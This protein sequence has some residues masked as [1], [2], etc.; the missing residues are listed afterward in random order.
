MTDRGSD[1][2]A[3][4]R[5][6]VLLEESADRLV[7]DLDQRSRLS[8]RERELARDVALL[9]AE[10]LPDVIRARPDNLRLA[11]VETRAKALEDWRLKTA[12]V[13]DRNGRLGRMDQAIAGNREQLEEALVAV[14]AELA[15]ARAELRA[16]IGTAEERK[17][18]RAA[19][20]LVNGAVRR[21]R[22][23]L[24]AVVTVVLGG[25]GYGVWRMRDDASRASGRLEQRL[26]QYD[27]DINRLYET[28]RAPRPDPTH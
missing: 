8:K 15:A 20:S 14:R 10:R 11:E 17:A 23:A 5:F 25:A 16:D 2:D 27:V 19:A 28:C 22:L 6:R 18:E 9:V 4:G 24:G 26:N 12:G 3:T 21:Y 13:D 7:E 1:R